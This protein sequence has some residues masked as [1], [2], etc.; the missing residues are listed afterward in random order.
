MK[1]RFNKS[2]G[3]SVSFFA[4]QDIITATTGFLLLIT[5]FLALN[6]T[7]VVSLSTEPTAGGLMTEKLR[8]VMAEIVDLKGKVNDGAPKIQEDEATLKRMI[9]ELKRSIARLSPTN[10]LAPLPAEES[11]LDRELRIEQQKLLTKL[12]A[13]QKELAEAAEGATETGSKI[14]ALERE[15]KDL[16]NRLQQAYDQKNKLRLIPERSGTSKEPVLVVI[17]KKAFRIQ[18]FD[19]SAAVEV[20]SL[21]EL[22]KALG[23]FPAANHYVV[24]YFK[25]SGSQMFND[26]TTHVRGLGYE[27]GY[28][29][30]PEAVTLELGGPEA[31]Q[32]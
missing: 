7:E 28:D 24:L 2:H 23:R 4:F 31:K 22:T 12:E 3:S 18:A 1:S 17:Q 6:I 20:G 27:I 29:L 30:L 9:E 16:Q 14:A 10:N 5:V 21:E 8:K 25:P 19:G 32:P 13:L 15:L 26:A 11:M